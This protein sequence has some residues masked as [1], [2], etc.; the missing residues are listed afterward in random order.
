M[1]DWWIFL[2]RCNTMPW[3]RRLRGR[4]GGVSEITITLYLSI[5]IISSSRHLR[6]RIN[7]NSASSLNKL[8]INDA[9]IL[10]LGCRLI[11]WVGVC[12]CNIYIVLMML[13][14][15]DWNMKRNWSNGFCVCWV[16]T[17]EQTDAVKGR[18]DKWGRLYS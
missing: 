8:L 6:I 4:G 17:G 1:I 12:A 15:I 11:K 7:L 9:S 14:R 10:A 13:S 3:L 18:E 5:L 2:T 16:S